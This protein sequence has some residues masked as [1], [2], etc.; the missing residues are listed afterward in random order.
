MGNLVIPHQQIVAGVAATLVW[1]YVDEDGTPGDAPGAVTVAVDDSTGAAVLADGAAALSGDVEGRYERAL[2]AAQ[3]ATLDV[4]SATW[5][6]DGDTVA[7]TLVEVRGPFPFTIAEARASHT[8]LAN[9]GKYPTEDL[10]EARTDVEDELEWICARAFTPR[11]RTVTLNGGG[12]R[13][14]HLPDGDLRS[15]RSCTVDGTA[16]SVGEL[17]DL[18]VYDSGRVERAAGDVWPWGQENV[19]IGYEFGL[20]RLPP[21]VKRASL[22]RLRELLNQD[23]R[24]VPATATQASAKGITVGLDRTEFETGNPLVDPVYRRWSRRVAA[25]SAGD[26]GKGAPA[27]PYGRTIVMAPQGDPLF[28]ARR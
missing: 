20:D 2:T 15:I 13:A 1:V 9:E 17:A 21:S 12:E 18:V 27:R 3:T 14:L 6:I 28:R 24:A 22:L 26:G 25:T 19:T 5:S 16:L 8:T 10:V 7:T 11:F 4:L 23:T